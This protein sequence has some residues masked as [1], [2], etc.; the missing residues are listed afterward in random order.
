MTGSH[1]W[2]ADDSFGN[3]KTDWTYTLWKKVAMLG[4]G[5]LY[6]GSYKINLRVSPSN[7]ESGLPNRDYANKL[8]SK[9]TLASVR[10]GY[11]SRHAQCGKA[12]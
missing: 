4:T 2:R 3:N 11:F 8:I 9:V 12:A 1:S 5:A 10:V 7:T 6:Q